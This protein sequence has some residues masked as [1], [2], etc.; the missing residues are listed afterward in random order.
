MKRV[1]VLALLAGVAGCSGDWITGG[2]L[3]RPGEPTGVITIDNQTSAN[4]TAVLI[5]NCSANTYGLNRLPD[6]ASIAPGETYSFTVSAG[7]WDVDVGYGWQT[8]YAE[9][10]Q[11]MD[12]RAYGQTVYTV[13]DGDGA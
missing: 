11:R 3:I 5:S 10:K 8:G 2:D 6:G 12:V 13:H 4:L 7:C 1:L 9:A